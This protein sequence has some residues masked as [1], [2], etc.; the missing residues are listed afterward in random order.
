[1]SHVHTEPPVFCVLTSEANADGQGKATNPKDAIGSAKLPLELV[2]QTAIAYE[3]VAFLEGACKYGRYNWRA[4]GVRASIYIAAA[5]RHAFKWWNGED[6]DPDTGVH[7]LASVRACFAI[8]LDALEC[9]KLT[10]DRPPRAPLGGLITRLEITAKRV[11]ELF[12]AHTPKQWTITDAIDGL[13]DAMEHTAASQ[14]K[15]P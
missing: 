7:H 4:G 10:D 12:K 3:S 6:C 2:P 14:T 15:A 8:I 11:R 5:M 9:G 13:S 1:M